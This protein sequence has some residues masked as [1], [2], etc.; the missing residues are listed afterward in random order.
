VGSCTRYL[1]QTVLKLEEH[2]IHDYRMWQRQELVAGHI[3][4]MAE[5][6]ALR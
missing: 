2:G 4:R 5:A 3:V 1:C 6:A